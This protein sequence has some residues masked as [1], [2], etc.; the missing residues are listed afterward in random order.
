MRESYLMEEESNLRL[1]LD[2][3]LLPEDVEPGTAERAENGVC[4]ASEYETKNVRQH[5]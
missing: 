5:F 1:L 3:S 4:P 2:G